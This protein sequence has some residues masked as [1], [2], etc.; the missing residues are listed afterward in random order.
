[1][2]KFFGPATAVSLPVPAATPSVPGSQAAAR[3][4]AN[5]HAACILLRMGDMLSK[6]ASLV[7]HWKVI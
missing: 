2:E 7:W 4:I 3:M 1:M 6:G 5:M